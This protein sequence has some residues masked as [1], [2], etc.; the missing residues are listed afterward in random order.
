MM[1]TWTVEDGVFS[2]VFV[3]LNYIKL[4]SHKP[5]HGIAF[6]P[7]EPKGSSYACLTRPYKDSVFSFWQ[8]FSRTPERLGL[9]CESSDS[10]CFTNINMMIPFDLLF[11][12][13]L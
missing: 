2:V 5:S 12:I 9:V 6:I 10:L 7:C 3:F 4:K 1:C 13:K 8:R 11:I